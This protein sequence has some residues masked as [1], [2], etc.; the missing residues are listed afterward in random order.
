[1]TNEYRLIKRQLTSF[2]LLAVLLC[3]AITHSHE[4][5]FEE[6]LLEQVECKLCQH[7]V[8]PPKQKVKLADVTIG[9]FSA[10]TLTPLI[11]YPK[12]CRYYSKC[13]RA[14]PKTA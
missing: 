10:E 9:C 6:P 11:F 5:T 14:P 13:P 2:L 3:S 1:M 12:F 7:L 4:L 8:D